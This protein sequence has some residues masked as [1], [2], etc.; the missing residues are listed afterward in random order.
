VAEP[1]RAIT[2]ARGG[3]HIPLLVPNHAVI[4][5]RISGT[6]PP[7]T[8]AFPSECTSH[9]EVTAIDLAARVKLS[10]TLVNGTLPLRIRPHTGMP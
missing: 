2:K 4:E 6:T 1:V 8:Q 9:G 3:E 7:E 5:Q 10:R